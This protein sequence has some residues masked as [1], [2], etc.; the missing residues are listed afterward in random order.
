MKKRFV[1]ADRWRTPWFR[2]LSPDAKHA[3]SYLCDNCDV[4]GVWEA[5]IALAD[6]SIGKALDW[7]AVLAEIGGRVAE[8]P[9]GKLWIKKFVSF[10]YVELTAKSPPHRG[11]IACIK[12]HGLE[13]QLMG[14]PAEADLPS[15]PFIPPAGDRIILCLA[16]IQGVDLPRASPAMRGKLEKARGDILAADPDVTPERIFQAAKAYRAKYR[17]AP[18]TAMGI[19]THWSEITPRQPTQEE[20]EE[21]ET[22]NRQLKEALRQLA[23][24]MTPNGLTAR[25]DLTELEIDEARDLQSIIT[26]IKAQ[27]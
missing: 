12:K 24:Y 25:A 23:G 4:A 27:L 20:I 3:W 19:A 22:L 14:T 7:P 6:F 11:I 8:L 18:V 21:K 26:S 13:L 2:G 17:S 10:Q 5:D 15:A 9:G 16:E 1:D